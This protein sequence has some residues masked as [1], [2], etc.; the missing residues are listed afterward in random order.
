[1][2]KE[3]KET[4]LHFAQE[5]VESGTLIYSDEW[6][7]YAD[8][9]VSGCN[10]ETVNYRKEFARYS[11]EMKIETNLIE[12]SCLSMKKFLRFHSYN[13]KIYVGI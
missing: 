13:E 10:H 4:L 5:F 1:M 12:A 6:K 7:G 11:N 3:T 8:I 9:R 2:N